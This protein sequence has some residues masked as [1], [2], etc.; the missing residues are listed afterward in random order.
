V[1]TTTTYD[2]VLRALWPDQRVNNLV[3]EAGPLLGLMPKDETFFEKT[4]HVALQYGNPQGRSATFANAQGNATSALF[5]DFA[6]T[7]VVDYG[8]GTID[9][10]LVEL[11]QLPGGAKGQV[12]D[13][14]ER[15]MKSSLE[16]LGRSIAK[17]MY[18]SGTGLRGVVGAE[19][20][21]SLTLTP[22]SDVKN[23]EVGMELVCAATETGA[24][25]DSGNSA[26]VTAIN[27]TTGVLTSDSNWTTQISGLAAADFL[28][29][30]GDAPAAGANKTLTGT[31]GW[32][33]D[34]APTSTAFFGVD[35]TA[36]LERQGGLRRDGSGDGTITESVQA[37]A[38]YARDHAGH[39]L[40]LTH[41]FF[42]PVDF[43][44]L[45]I[46]LGTN[47]RYVQVMASDVPV[48][49]ADGRMGTQKATIGYDA[50]E[51]FTAAGRI[52][53]FPDDFVPAGRHMAL[54]LDTWK[55]ATMGKMV[56]L[57]RHDGLRV[58]RQASA[59]GVEFRNRMRGQ[60]YTDAPGWNVNA[61]IPT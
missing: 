47:R 30:E 56:Q 21:V 49:R 2:A 19:S 29:V 14:M 61:Q 31:R 18:G 32:V 23:F 42:N 6:I 20:T 50:V 17:G 51:V 43:G 35:R 13:G 34:A 11:S 26:T 41:A 48:K 4:R 58:A 55:L 1:A 53:C 27:R 54:R 39:G 15:E 46:E 33:P 16:E 52:L 37:S 24:L 40:K 9:G 60:T 10:E 3:L 59:D 57:I 44:N 25:R 28:F 45:V 38:H 7:K 5:S 36:D 8:V 22:I 12:I